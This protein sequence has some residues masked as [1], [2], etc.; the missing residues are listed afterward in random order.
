M[1]TVS[2]LLLACNADTTAST[3]ATTSGTTLAE[4]TTGAD[5]P[6][7]DVDDTGDTTAPP[8]PDTT[9]TADITT[10][11]DMPPLDCPE[12]TPVPADCGDLPGTCGNATPI[13]GGLFHVFGTAVTRDQVW[14]Q[15]NAGDGCPVGLYRARKDGSD[16]QRVRAMDTVLDL[17]SDEHA[18][19]LV[20]RTRDPYTLRVLA[21]VD[22]VETIVGETHGDPDFNSYF[23][24]FL[25]RTLTGVVTYDSGGQKTPP[26]RRVTP[27]G[28]TVLGHEVDDGAYLGSEPA[29]DGERVFYARNDPGF[30]DE[31][32]HV[33]VHRQLLGLAGGASVVLADGAT[34]R[35]WQTIAVDD[36]YVYFATGEQPEASGLA[37]LAKSGGPVTPLIAPTDSGIDKVLVDDTHV[38]Y[39]Q[40]PHD[41]F[42]V[43]KTGGAPRHVWHGEYDVESQQI[44]QDADH[45]YFAVHAPGGDIPPPGI[46]FIVRVAKATTLP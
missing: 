24:T 17:E 30:D 33:S 3:S 7:A 5:D 8:D 31:P 38:Y 9:D 27:A 19:Y 15:Q 23:Y 35:G 43:E 20:E 46:D 22:D 4:L 41:I 11:A 6:T 14:F 32:G 37:R 39:H 40:R 1:A 42:A 10:G 25:T 13:A 29:Y 18:V 45:L 36:E 16:A 34:A 44:Q 28:L 2:L 12:T 26:F 21:L